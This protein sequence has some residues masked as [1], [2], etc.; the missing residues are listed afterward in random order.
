M[1]VED[2]DED[3]HE[4]LAV[5]DRAGRIQIP[6]EYLNSIGVEGRDKLKVELEDNKIVLMTPRE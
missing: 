5:V 4:E 3:T 6:K 1:L 2:D